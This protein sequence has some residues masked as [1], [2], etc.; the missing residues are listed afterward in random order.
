MYTISLVSWVNIPD[1]WETKRVNFRRAP[2]SFEDRASR[3][4]LT[5]GTQAQPH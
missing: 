5:E 4:W 3:P 1:R 2:D